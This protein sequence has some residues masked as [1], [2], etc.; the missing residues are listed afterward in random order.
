MSLW[1]DIRAERRAD[2]AARAKM[3]L[4]R[5]VAL[6]AERRQDRAAAAAR[7]E[8]RREERRDVWKARRAALPDLAYSAMWATLIVLPL[9]LAWGPQ[10]AFALHTLH[11]PGVWSNAFPASIETGAWVCILESHRRIRAG[12]SPGSLQRWAW[13][14]AGIAAAINA[15]HGT[16]DSGIPAGLALGALSLLGVL[17]H[18]I[19]QRLHQADQRGGVAVV[20]RAIW[21]WLRYPRLSIAAASI[22]GARDLDPVAAWRLAWEDRYGVGP[23]STRRER[24][25]GRVIVRREAR[26]HR[27]AA[28]SGQITI[29]AGR[30]QHGWAPEV[31]ECLD[32]HQQA[33][34]DLASHAADETR[35]IV[36]DV[37]ELANTLT[38]QGEQ[39][40]R[41]MSARAAELLPMLRDAID[42]G[43]VPSHPSVRTIRMWA[44]HDHS[45]RIGVPVAQELRDEAHRLRVVDDPTSDNGQGDNTEREA[46]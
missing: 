29:I 31:R 10:A 19:R 11:I 7:R 33:A 6:S 35:Q 32:A 23:E 15:A 21:R 28:R 13:L 8:A 9:T 5:Q 36:Q 2:E 27:K 14:L 30:V 24:R 43:T 38:E 3:E 4:A 22:R 26:E 45:E 42:A 18:H 1:S 20:R 16:A 41:G 37:Q 46:S 34:L 17:L 40:Q 44:R 39:G 25:L 12:K